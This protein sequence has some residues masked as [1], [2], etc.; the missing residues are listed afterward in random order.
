[1]LGSSGAQRLPLT[2]FPLEEGLGGPGHVMDHLIERLEVPE[3]L[4]C[5]LIHGHRVNDLGRD[6][7]S[8]GRAPLSTQPQPLYPPPWYL[9]GHLLHLSHV[10][11]HRLLL[12]H[13]PQAVPGIPAGQQQP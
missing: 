6:R 4:L 2:P 7:R 13:P 8:L 5:C 1:M 9:L 10:S 12:G 11:L 3:H